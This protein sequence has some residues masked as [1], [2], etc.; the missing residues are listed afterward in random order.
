ME[1]VGAF[2]VSSAAV[3]GWAVGF[4]LF[5]ALAAV[6]Y[7]L[8]AVANYSDNRYCAGTFGV[9][10]HLAAIGFGTA[11]LVTWWSTPG[12]WSSGWSS[13][14]TVISGLIATAIVL[15]GPLVA[16]RILKHKLD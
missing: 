16:G 5:A 11:L 1:S 6:L 7:W 8:S 10:C 3:G 12:T 4:A 9:I 2:G 14:G 13:L 15:V